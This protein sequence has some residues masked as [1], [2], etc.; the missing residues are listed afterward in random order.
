MSPPIERRTLVRSG[1]ASIIA[2]TMV[3]V[4]ALGAAGAAK[5]KIVSRHTNGTQ[6][7][8]MSVSGG[9][10]ANGRYVVFRS[11]AKTLIGSDTN[12]RRDI[13][14]RD[15]KAG[16]TR[17]ANRRDNGDQAN[18]VSGYP[19]ISENGRY[20]V[21][22]SRATNLI[23]GG[24]NGHDQIYIHDRVKRKTRLISKH[25]NGTQGDGES[26]DPVVSADGRFVAFQSSA[27][28]LVN[29]D[30]NGRSDIFIRDRKTGKTRLVSKRSNGAQGNEGSFTAAIST[31]GRFIAFESGASNLVKNDD[32]DVS[33]VFVHDRK[34]RKTKR[35]SVSSAESEAIGQST[36]ADI[37]ADGRFVVF[38]SSAANLVGGDGN[39]VHD[40]FIRDRKKGRTRRLSIHTN[41]SGG[42]ASSAAPSISGDGRRVVFE[43]SAPNL[44]GGDSNGT[45]D[46]FMRDRRKKRTK[47]VSVANGGGQGTG[48]S[49]RPIISR[50]GRF[51]TFYSDAP[52]LAS[53]DVNA[54]HDVFA[55]GPLR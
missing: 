9:I 35:V 3:A 4:L 40:V 5:T 21:F 11:E 7:D 14:V 31:N 53:V 46:I 37:S 34:K 50:D 10:S 27:S 52:D 18:H 22:W 38:R 54:R 23:G 2:C 42:S 24:T 20:V 36:Q 6:G 45:T 19:S 51:V 49:R 48:I 33:D 41:G 55:R 43:S 39:G 44:V 25:S 12:G 15:R 47:R 29:G 16:K 8:Q 30:T 13:F 26:R 1:G 32:N 28:N 17:L